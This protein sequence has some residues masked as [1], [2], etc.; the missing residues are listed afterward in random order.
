MDEATEIYAWTD[1]ARTAYAR[2]RAH[3]GHW[4][5]EWGHRDPPGGE[6]EIEAGRHLL[7][8]PEDAVER[9]VACVRALSDDPAD[10]VRAERELRDLLELPPHPQP[11]TARR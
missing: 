6:R 3:A 7:S 2:L 4:R 1:R 9:M 5:L 10:A 8:D 11:H